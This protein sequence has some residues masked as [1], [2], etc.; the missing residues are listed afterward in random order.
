MATIVRRVIKKQG[1]VVFDQPLVN[2]K[3]SY[4]LSGTTSAP[5]ISVL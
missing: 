1:L 4:F 5:K 3:T 2:T